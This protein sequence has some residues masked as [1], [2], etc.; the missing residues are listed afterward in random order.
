MWHEITIPQPPRPIR[1]YTQAEQSL[2]FV[3]TADGLYAFD[4]TQQGVW[5]HVADAM[6]EY[7]LYKEEL[8]HYHDAWGVIHFRDAC[9]LIHGFPTEDS[10]GTTDVPMDEH[11]PTRDRLVYDDLSDTLQV[12]GVPGNEI[13]LNVPNFGASEDAWAT[14]GFSKD[15]QFLTVGNLH[16]IRVFRYS[17]E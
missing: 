10:P 6:S 4:L 5:D 3:C 15:G 11:H 17:S 7:M 2:L 8:L 16:R 12:I 14:A 13:R 1:A 9:F